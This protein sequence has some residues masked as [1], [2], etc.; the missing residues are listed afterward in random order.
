MAVIKRRPV[1]TTNATEETKVKTGK[2]T[3][4]KPRRPITELLE[5]WK[6]SE[7]EKEKEKEEGSEVEEVEGLAVEETEGSAIEEG[8]EIKEIDTQEYK[9]IKTDIIQETNKNYNLEKFQ[10][11]SSKKISRSNLVAGVMSVVNS[12]YAKRVT[13]SRGLMDK[14]NNPTKVAI[15]FSDESIAIGVTLPNNNNQLD[16][17]IMGKNGVIY[18]AGIVS[19]ITDKYKLNFSNRTSITF[20]EVEYIKSDGCTIAIINAKQVK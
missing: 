7:K 19:E 18:S 9:E 20:S 10:P 13:L 16:V 2:E 1:P 3:T 6:H 8:Q 17:K 15:S 5:E 4:R 11:S 12:K 14:L